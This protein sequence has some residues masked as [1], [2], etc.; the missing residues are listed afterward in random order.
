MTTF[1][2]RLFIAAWISA[3]AAG[4][5]LESLAEGDSWGLVFIAMALVILGYVVVKLRVQAYRAETGWTRHDKHAVVALLAGA[6]TL[7]LRGLLMADSP[8]EWTLLFA[9]ALIW[10]AL[11]GGYAL[12]RRA[13]VRRG[14]EAGQRQNVSRES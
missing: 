14:E 13:T 2:S 6:L 12:L 1:D 10:V 8:A 4:L 9:A 11:A 5:G 7:V 3:Y